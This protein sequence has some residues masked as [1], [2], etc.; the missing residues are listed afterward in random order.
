MQKVP[1]YALGIEKLNC[2]KKGGNEIK[3][4]IWK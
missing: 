4:C 1:A 2:L 3:S